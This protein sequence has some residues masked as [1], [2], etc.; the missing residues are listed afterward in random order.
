MLSGI[1]GRVTTLSRQRLSRLP[2]SDR[3]GAGLGRTED[4]EE[5]QRLADEG[6]APALGQTEP[7][8][9]AFT[10][11]VAA[12]AINELL[13][14]LIGYGPPDRPNET[15]LRLHEREIRRTGRRRAKPI[16]ATRRRGGGAPVP[17]SRSWDTLADVMKI[18]WW[19]W[20]SFQRW[21]IVGEAESPTRFRIDC[22]ATA[23]RSSPRPVEPSGSCS[24][25]PAGL[26]TGSCST[27]TRTDVRIGHCSRPNI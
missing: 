6:Y 15:L 22:R 14:R 8:V 5:R 10:T 25:A 3:H 9:V 26:V 19:E 21:R 13:D 12:G 23:S 20:L 24:I 2:Q 4:A 18:A 11:A 7:A 17:R 27:P 16:T 1:D